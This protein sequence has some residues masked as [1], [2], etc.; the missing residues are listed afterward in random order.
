MTD[1][2]TRDDISNFLNS[3]FGLTKKDCNELVKDIIEEI[4]NGMKKTQKGE[5]NICI[6]NKVVKKF[7]TEEDAKI[8]KN[9]NNLGINYNINLKRSVKVHNFGT[10]KIKNK[11]SRKARN[12]KTKIE[13][14]IPPRK[15]IS[16][17]PSKFILKKINKNVND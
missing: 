13:V 1:N 17:I 4:I 2:I 14:M 11:K 10:F 8:Y 5:W 15:V 3:E 6:G 16:F 12:P 9:E 7:D